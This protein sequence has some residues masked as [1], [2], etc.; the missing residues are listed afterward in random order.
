MFLNGEMVSWKSYDDGFMTFYAD[1]TKKYEGQAID[2]LFRGVQAQWRYF[3]LCIFDKVK[4]G[5]AA[6]EY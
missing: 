1:Y 5:W 4:Y 2:I 6:Y 3:S